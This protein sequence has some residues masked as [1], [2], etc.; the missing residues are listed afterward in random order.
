MSPKRKTTT[1]ATEMRPVLVR[2]LPVS[3]GDLDDV[4]RNKTRAEG[5]LW[6]RSDV[7]RCAIAQYLKRNRRSK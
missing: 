3:I 5:V 7:V 4:A 1:P 2:M 6:T